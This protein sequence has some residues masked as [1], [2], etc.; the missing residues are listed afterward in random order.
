MSQLGKRN[1]KRLLRN[2]EQKLRTKDMDLGPKDTLLG[3]GTKIGTLV[4]SQEKLKEIG[5]R[6]KKIKELGTQENF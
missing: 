5:I 3:K 6:N 2:Q 1:N 4:T